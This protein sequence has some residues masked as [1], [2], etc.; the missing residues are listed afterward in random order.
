MSHRD[1]IRAVETAARPLV[2]LDEPAATL[3]KAN[4]HLRQAGHKWELVAG[5]PSQASPVW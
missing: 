1:A 4:A 2:L 5:R 3:G